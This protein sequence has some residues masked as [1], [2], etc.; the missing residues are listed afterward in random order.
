MNSNQI[1]KEFLESCLT[2]ELKNKISDYCKRCLLLIEKVN[3]TGPKNETYQLRHE[4]MS[5]GSFRIEKKLLKAGLKKNR[6]YRD[7]FLVFKSDFTV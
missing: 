7:I 5:A 2:P 4:I 6:D 1:A 3:S